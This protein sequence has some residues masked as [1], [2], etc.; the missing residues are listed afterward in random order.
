MFS[1]K[2]NIERKDIYMI[3]E[4]VDKIA[5]KAESVSEVVACQRPEERRGG[6]WW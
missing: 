5:N 2:E 4:A 1:E 6:R 3:S